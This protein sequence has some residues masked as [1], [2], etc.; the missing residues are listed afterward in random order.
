M[1]PDH[2]DGAKVLEYTDIGHYGFLTDYD[3]NNTP[4]EKEVCFLA[5]CHYEG[6]EDGFYLFS[7]DCQYDVL[8]DSFLDT[9]EQCRH[10]AHL[11]E[12]TVW[13]RK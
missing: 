13:N 3:E 11:P 10:C 1:F 7:C 6:R 12:E 2:L 4:L 5:I 9:M 8:M